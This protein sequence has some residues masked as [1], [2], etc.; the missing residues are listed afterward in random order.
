MTLII[1]DPNLAHPHGHHM[2]WDLA[3]AAAARDREQDALIFAHRDCPLV[4]KEGL[5][6]VRLFSHSTYECKYKDR[7]AGRFDDFTYFNDKLASDLALIPRDRL[8][9]TDAV[10]VPTLTENHLLGYVSWMRTFNAARAPL[11]V[12][13]LMFPSGLDFPNEVGARTVADPLQAL[14]YRLAFR[15]AAEPG[16][17]IHFFGSGRQLAREYSELAGSMIEAHPIPYDP[18]SA[19]S[20]SGTARPAALLFVGDAKAD[21]GF[22]FIPELAD[23]LCGMWPGWDFLIHANLGSS[24]G[25]ALEAYDVLTTTVVPRHNNLIVQTGRLSRKDY[26]ELMDKADCLIATYDP[27]VYARKSSGVVWEAI[28]LGLPMLVPAD[29][30]LENEAREWGAGCRSYKDFSV[31]GIIESFEDFSEAVPSLRTQSLE[32]AERYQVHN[33]MDALMDQIGRLWAPRMLAASLMSQPRSSFLQLE[34]IEREGWS[35][36]ETMNGNIV[37]WTSKSFEIDFSWPFNV[38]WQVDIEVAHFIGREQITRARAFANERELA[39]R[40][41]MSGTGNSG[42]LTISGVGDRHRS[43][44]RV[45]VEL[46]WTSTPPGETRDLG[47]LVRSI[48]VSPGE[49]AERIGRMGQVEV[50]TNVTNTEA[51]EDFLLDGVVSGRALMNPHV[52]NWLHFTVRANGGPEVARAI[53]VYVNGIPMRVDSFA[54]GNNRWTMKV[55]CGPD[56]LAAIGYWADWDLVCQPG[57][58]SQVWIANLFVSESEEASALAGRP[59]PIEISQS[60]KSSFVEATTQMLPIPSFVSDERRPQD[61]EES[62]VTANALPDKSDGFYGLEYTPKGSA[63]RWTGPGSESRFSLCINRSRPV[64]LS[65]QIVSLG[66]NRPL[67]LTAE[68]DGEIYPLGKGD[69]SQ[70][71]FTAGPLRARTGDDPTKVTLRVSRLKRPSEDGAKDTRTLGVALAWIRAEPTKES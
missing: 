55:K 50:F 4:S 27:V 33:G 17:P 19:N 25:P 67:D 10:L 44:V 47:V 59:D 39:T 34:D 5:E 69:G 16:T 23:R 26:L 7:I 9:A 3:I 28:S 54:T 63:F 6:I 29:T 11:F 2:E 49:T 60:G 12:V 65:F 68:V 66:N 46:P 42:S 30:W 20:Q 36:P 18:R 40:A 62:L 1:L 32:A 64:V 52:D 57:S 8:R 48:Q 38:P 13:Y 31:D 58:D 35:F 56:I 24:W 41:S 22:T 21:K 14:F 37:R 51:G 70:S 53:E 45:R 15:R 61:G 43:A 71:A